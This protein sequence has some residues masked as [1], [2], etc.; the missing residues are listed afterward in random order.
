[1]SRYLAFDLGASNGRCILGSVAGDHLSLEVIH[2]FENRPVELLDRLYWDILGIYENLKYGLVKA[3]REHPG[4]FISLGIDAW[5]CDFALLDEQGKL[6]GNPYCYRDPHTKGMFAEA[7]RRVSKEEIFSQTGLQFIELNTLFQLLALQVHEDPA[8]RSAATFL[9]L[10]DLLHYWL[11]G[12][13]ACEYTEASTSQ[14]LDAQGRNW[15]YPLIRSLNFPEE[16]FPPVIQPGAD[17]GFLRPS[18][19]EEVGLKGLR[20]TATATHDTAAAVAAAPADCQH[21]GYISSGTWALLGRELDQ[22]LVTPECMQY[23]ITN[24]G[25]IFGKIL[26]LRNI[27]NLWL[28]QECRRSWMMAGEELSWDL[29][30][31]LAAQA[32]PFL[33]FV[34]PDDPLF[35]APGDMPARIQRTCRDTGQAVPQT[36]GEIVRV[37]LESL[38]YKYRFTFERLTRLTSEPVEVM[39]I[40]GGGS[41]NR[42][43]NQFAANALQVPVIAGPEEATAAGNIL[44]QM[45]A[46]GELNSLEEARG[47]VRRSFPTEEF[48]PVAKDR[49]EE[50]YTRFLRVSRLEPYS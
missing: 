45:V 2:R 22:P 23:N 34:D 24:E 12:V 36:K 30:V 9:H 28:V 43:L 47:L 50:N 25:G 1:M 31:N 8:Y 32:G 42:L 26:L 4:E 27:A 19:A 5:G 33:A 40:I 37:V 29:L 7:F 20:L 38:A 16:I 49:W 39:H 13:K 44:T 21:F 35:L 48:L 3:G 14:L 41:R 10:P 18:V 46:A 6:V 17:L 11:T 15:A